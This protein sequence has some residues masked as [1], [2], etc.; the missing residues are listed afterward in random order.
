MPPF[1]GVSS[2]DTGDIVI[3]GKPPRH[4]E[5]SF[6]ADAG[7][8]YWFLYSGAT[9]APYG[10]M[11]ANGFRLRATGGYGAYEYLGPFKQRYEATTSFYEGLFGYLQQLGPLTAKAFVGVAQIDH[12][13]TERHRPGVLDGSE[14]G[15]K[16]VVE[17][18]LNV[19]E[20]WY[21]S[22]DLSYASAHETRSARARIGYRVDPNLSFGLEARFNQDSQADYKM[23]A[24]ER[25]EL[26]TDALDYT[27]VGAFARYEW[28]TGEISASGGINAGGLNSHGSF[29]DDLLA[30]A[31]L[32]FLTRF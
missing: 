11:H 23:S 8:D 31:T 14:F 15:F 1:A 3:D 27:W 18:W 32:N 17:L 24:A 2:L 13:T 29:G 21:A 28:E 20:D 26:Q 7:T 4:L 12:R 22:L 16:G 25:P 5:T 9:F 19:D 6:G 10:D 30:Y